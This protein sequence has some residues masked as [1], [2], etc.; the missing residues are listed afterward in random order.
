MI[1]AVQS[2]LLSS[3]RALIRYSARLMLAWEPVMVTCLSVEPSTGLA[4]LIW[5]PDI[6]RISLIFAPWRPMMQPMSWGRT[7]KWLV[8]GT[9]GEKRKKKSGWRCNLHDLH[10]LEWSAHESQSAQR[11]PS[12]LRGTRETT[13][14]VLMITHLYDRSLS[15]HLPWKPWLLCAIG[16]G[17]CCI[18]SWWSLVS[19]WNVE[20]KDTKTVLMMGEK[21]I[22]LEFCKYFPCKIG[23]ERKKWDGI[24]K[25]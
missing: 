7:N 1:W 4:I 9:T 25:K 5:A 19:C 8:P 21:N 11:R 18:A 15:A 12:Q 20:G 10:R 14:S 13:V 6:W 23:D 16:K 2:S 22:Q 24:W 17:L 3:Y